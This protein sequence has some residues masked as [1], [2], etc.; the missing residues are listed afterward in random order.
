MKENAVTATQ[1]MTPSSEAHRQPLLTCTPSYFQPVIVLGVVCPVLPYRWQ[2]RVLSCSY[3]FFTPFQVYC[4]FV[5]STQHENSL[6]WK[7]V[8]QKEVNLPQSLVA[9]LCTSQTAVSALHPVAM[10]QW[11][12]MHRIAVRDVLKNKVNPCISQCRLAW[13]LVQ[14]C[15]EKAADCTVFPSCR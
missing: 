3:K 5:C 15:L 10:P 4:C 9:A 13:M 14:D 12:A 11:H 6:F 8:I 1:K 7:P 2:E